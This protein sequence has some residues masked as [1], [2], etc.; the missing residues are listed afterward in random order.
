MLAILALLS[1]VLAV[2]SITVTAGGNTIQII[3]SAVLSFGLAVLFCCLERFFKKSS[4]EWIRPICYYFSR[5]K[6]IYKIESRKVTLHY[7]NSDEIKYSVDLQCVSTQKELLSITQGFRWNGDDIQ[8]KVIIGDSV[9]ITSFNRTQDLNTFEYK[10]ETIFNKNTPFSIKYDITNLKDTF[11]RATYIKSKIRYKTKFLELCILPAENMKIT[12]V[13]LIVVDDNSSML[14]K[15]KINEELISYDPK[16]GGYS[17]IIR[18][19]KRGY[20]YVLDWKVCD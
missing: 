5:S 18:Y 12:D 13:K 8:P 7:I 15:N 6:N 9:E 20:T 19:P 16:I 3:L 1:F 10:I 17:K 2:A 11:H 4:T 14:N